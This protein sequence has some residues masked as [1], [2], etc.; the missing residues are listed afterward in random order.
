ML[1]G[2]KEVPLGHGQR[3]GLRDTDECKE[4]AIDMNE[5]KT[6]IPITSA[7]EDKVILEEIKRS[8]SQR[9][10]YIIV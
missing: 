10:D 8:T 3:N 5:A 1:A 9:D 2:P 6:G 4:D 7:A